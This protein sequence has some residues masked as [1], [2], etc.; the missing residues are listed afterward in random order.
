MAKATKLTEGF[1]YF[2]YA[3]EVD[4]V[5]IGFTVNLKQRFKELQLGSPTALEMLTYVRGTF[6]LE[7]AILAIFHKYRL[8]GEWFQAHPDL[9]AFIESLCVAKEYSP[10]MLVA[11]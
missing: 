7:L 11:K 5:K 10:E 6:Q 8:H 1:V 3:P 2:I 4:R 9:L